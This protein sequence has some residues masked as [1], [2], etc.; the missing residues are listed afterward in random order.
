MLP[1]LFYSYFAALRKAAGI[2]SN[3]LLTTMGFASGYG[4]KRRSYIFYQRGRNFF[5]TQWAGGVILLLFVVVAMVL[6]NLPAT[7]H[8]YHEI[9]QAPVGVIIGRFS[10]EFELEKFVNDGLMMIFFFLIGLEIKREVV[11]GHLS[12]FKQ[13]ILPI[14]GALG[15]MLIPAAIY[16]A[17]NHGTPY[18]HGWGIPM[19]T[20]IAFAIAIMSVMGSR[21]PVSFKI[22]LTAL[23]VADDLGAIIV[24]AVFY[25]TAINFNLLILAA[26]LLFGTWLL[27]KFKIN[28][29][30][31]YVLI[32]IGLWFLFYHSGVH[33][34]IAG[35]LLA[36]FIPST[37][38]YNKRYFLNKV[39]YLMDDFVHKDKDVPVSANNAQWLDLHKIGMIASESASLSQR[40]EHLLSPWVN[41]LIMPLFA[42]VNAGVQI[43]AVGDLNILETTQGL[44]ILLGLWIGKPLGIFLFSWLFVKTRLA[45]MPHGGSWKMFIAVAC[46]GGIGF[47]MSIFMDT[48]AFADAPQFISSG[49]IAV[50]AAS[51]IASVT[52]VLMINSEY[53]AEKR[54][55]LKVSDSVSET[56]H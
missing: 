32:S 48:L 31:P 41:Y 17:L 27:T 40:F 29:F 49:K 12:S 21:V 56:A 45:V 8:F 43:N 33:A 46:L 28:T 5:N 47:T 4:F 44:G 20:D 1:K 36:I 11:S 37:P 2:S 51:V 38:K 19:A 18:H 53:K 23:A 52:G 10:L 54:R 35:V 7:S 25:G 3:K 9:I 6:A 15:G 22:F 50:L 13:S 42:L 39:K 34:T 16:V 55:A 24:I 14:A 26:I 30:L